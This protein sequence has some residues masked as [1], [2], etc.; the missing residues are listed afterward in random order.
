MNVLSIVGGHNGLWIDITLLLL[1]ELVETLYRCIRY[2]C[3]VY[4]TNV[5]EKIPKRKQEINNQQV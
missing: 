4:E 2:H 5:K 1:T 3:Y